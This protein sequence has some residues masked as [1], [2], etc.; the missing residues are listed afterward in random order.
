MKRYNPRVEQTRKKHRLPAWAVAPTF[1]LGIII[2]VAALVMAI[3][4]E[5]IA[6][7]DPT[8]V[9]ITVRTKAPSAEHIFGTDNYGRDVFSRVVW[10]T[11]IDL[12]IGFFGVLVPM[13]IG[14]IIGLLA[15]WYGGWLDSLLMR[16]SEIMMAFPFTIL[17]IAIITIL[18]TGTINLY[19]A[20]W[21]VGWMSYARL[22]RAEVLKLK[23]AEFIEAARVAGFSD[24]RILL[25]HILPNVISSSIVFAASDMVMCM[26]TGA[27]MSFLGLGVQPPTPEWG[28]LLSNSR[29]YFF[30]SLHYAV[31]PGLAILLTVLCFNLLGDGL[32]S[33]LDPRLSEQ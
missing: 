5:Q 15:A 4:P 3:F 30:T 17:V 29:Q 12:S 14:G 20:L 1:I 2:V 7:Y 28:L 19:I 10:G 27:S 18:G 32:R 9:D 26:L 11:R 22:V 33:A 21:L 25:R 23:K 31:F 8:A 6:P 16:I 13:I 24:A